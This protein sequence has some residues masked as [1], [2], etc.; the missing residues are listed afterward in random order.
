MKEKLSSIEPSPVP[1]EEPIQVPTII[2]DSIHSVSTSDHQLNSIDG[3]DFYHE[4][5]NPIEVMDEILDGHNNGD[6]NID[7]YDVVDISALQINNN[8][9]QE[10]FAK[11]DIIHKEDFEKSEPIQFAEIVDINDKLLHVNSN[12]VKDNPVDRFCFYNDPRAQMDDGAKCSV[13]NIVEILQDVKWFN[14]KNKAPVPM[15]GATSGNIIVPSA[16]GKLRVQAQT[17]P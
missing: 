17:K 4:V 5:I 10:G 9:S 1:S 13:T 2:T 12:D 16:Q 15:Q 8:F 6:T 3:N 14:G 7:W 11:A